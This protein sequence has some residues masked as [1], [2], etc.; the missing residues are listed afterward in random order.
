MAAYLF[1]KENVLENI[2]MSGIWIKY[3]ENDILLIN[4]NGFNGIFSFLKLSNFGSRKKID[5]PIKLIY[6][7]FK[8]NKICKICTFKQFH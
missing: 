8:K 1:E 5:K 4:W 7:V 3:M 2:C 6:M